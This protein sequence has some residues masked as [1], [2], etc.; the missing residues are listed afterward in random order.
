[1]NN[2]FFAAF[3]VLV[4]ALVSL[5]VL[6]LIGGD[7]GTTEVRGHCVVTTHVDMWGNRIAPTER[8]CP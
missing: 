5:G 7:Y 2:L 8:V 3:V 6:T 4:I 1:M